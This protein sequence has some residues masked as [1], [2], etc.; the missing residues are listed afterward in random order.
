MKL[1]LLTRISKKDDPIWDCNDGA[2]V[3][4]TSEGHARLIANAELRGD[5]G[6]VWHNPEGAT[7]EELPIDGDAGIILVDFHAG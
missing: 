6:H 3:R 1:Y 5:E 4:A 2:V 7:C